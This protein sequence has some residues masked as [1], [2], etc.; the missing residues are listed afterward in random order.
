M[1]RHGGA[2]DVDGTK[3][4]DGSESFSPKLRFELELPDGQMVPVIGIV[5]S[6]ADS[7]VV[8]IALLEAYGVDFASLPP[9]KPSKGMGPGMIANGR[10]DARARYKGTVFAES[11]RVTGAGGAEVALLGRGDFFRRFDVYFEWRGSLP[12]FYLEAKEP[13]GDEEALTAALLRL[14]DDE[15]LRLALSAGARAR[16]SM[17]SWER[18]GK[19]ALAALRE[20][21][22]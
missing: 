13:P 22:A 12:T 2:R 14:A 17:L 5:D 11:I 7:T 21:A 20:A 19:A 9:L 1:E 18:A 6:G 3:L 10:L 15:G 8:N 16:A 4:L